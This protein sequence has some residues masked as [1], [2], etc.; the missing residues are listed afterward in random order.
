MG[1]V[2][3]EIV[4]VGVYGGWGRGGV[5]VWLVVVGGRIVEVGVR[6]GRGMEIG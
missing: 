6:D 5:G 4:G 1:L 3:V 2:E